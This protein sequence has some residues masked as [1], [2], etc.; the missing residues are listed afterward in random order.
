MSQRD[1]DT[2]SMTWVPYI[3][4][5]F[6]KFCSLKLRRLMPPLS[7]V[8]ASFNPF[9]AFPEGINIIRLYVRR[10]IL[11][12]S[13]SDPPSFSSLASL[14]PSSSFLASLVS[15]TYT[16]PLHASKERN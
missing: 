11:L 3:S 1:C 8:S 13:L 16:K 9:L 15:S 5:A 14:V 7:N 2:Y 12:D 10:S 4:V 6:L